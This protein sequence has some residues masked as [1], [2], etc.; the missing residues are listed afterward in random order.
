MIEV[1][2]IGTRQ[3]AERLAKPPDPI[4][5]D[6]RRRCLPPPHPLATPPLSSP[7]VIFGSLLLVN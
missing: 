3:V 7:S 5:V 6:M 2:A 1:D 4:T